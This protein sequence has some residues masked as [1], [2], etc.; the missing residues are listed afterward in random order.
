MKNRIVTLV[1]A[2][3]LSMVLAGCRSDCRISCEKYKECLAS[4]LDED[5]CTDTCSTKS[6]DD[7]NFQTRAEDC[8]QCVEDKTCSEATQRCFDECLAVVT[9][10]P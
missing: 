6:D 2:L 5:K 7:S 10:S 1:A 9:A 3:G 4:D 8:A